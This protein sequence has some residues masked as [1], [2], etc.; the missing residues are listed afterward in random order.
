MKKNIKK[1]VPAPRALCISVTASLAAALASLMLFAFYISSRDVPDAVAQSAVYVSFAVACG[2]GGLVCG[3]LAGRRGLVLGAACGAAF[4]GLLCIAGLVYSAVSGAG[5]ALA[6]EGGD[7]P[8]RLVICCAF[9]MAGG[10]AGVNL[11]GARRRAGR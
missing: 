7:M 6:A 11:A 8:L 4:F 1:A 10:I 9:G 2:L 3:I 5:P